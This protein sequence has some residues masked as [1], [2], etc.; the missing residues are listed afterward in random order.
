MVCVTSEDGP[1]V[2]YRSILVERGKCIDAVQE[3]F[4]VACPQ[5]QGAVVERQGLRCLADAREGNGKVV[6]RIEMVSVDRQRCFEMRNRFAGAAGFDQASAEIGKSYRCV[7]AQRQGVLQRG[8]CFVEAPGALEGERMVAHPCRVGRITFPRASQRGKCGRNVA[9][10][11]F[12][13]A[14]QRQRIGIIGRVSKQPGD[15]ST[16]L[17]GPWSLRQL[18]GALQH[19]LVNLKRPD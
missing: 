6:Q 12:D 16:S 3:R 7:R 15:Q 9:G 2:V 13:D 11:L 5:L 14:K 1:N 19:S 10:A 18:R 17:F 4:E 8:N